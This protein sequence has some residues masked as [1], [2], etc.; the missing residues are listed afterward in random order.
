MGRRK[1][2]LTQILV[3]VA[4]AFSCFGLLLFIWNAFGGPVPFTPEGYR[5]KVPF[6]EGTQLAVESDV[7]I[8]NVSVGKVKAI[9]LDTT[10]QPE[11]TA[12]ATIQVDS[13][14]APIPADTRAMLRQKTL[15]G[16]TYVELTPGSRAAGGPMLAEGE[17]LPAAQVAESVQLDEIF[18]SLD[19]RTRAAFRVWM[20][21]AAAATKGRGSDI[22]YALGNLEPFTADATRLVGILDRQDQALGGLVRNAGEVFD[23]LSR[24]PGQLRGLIVNADTVFTTTA[25]R[26]RSLQELFVTLPTFQRE[27][28][29]TLRSAEAFSRTATPVL[30]GFQP[31]AKALGGTL[32]QVGRISPQLEGFSVGLQEVEAS[33]VQGF[34]ALGDLLVDPNLLPA[35]L[36]QSTPFTKEV[37]PLLTSFSQYRRELAGALGNL[38]AAT[39]NRISLGDQPA[40][41]VLRTGLNVNPNAAAAYPTGRLTYSRSNPYFEPGGGLKYFVPTGAF[42]GLNARAFQPCA[43]GITAQLTNGGPNPLPA[44]Y[45]DLTK[46]FYFA[47]KNN[48][49]QIAAPGCTLQAPF[50]SIGSPSENTQYQHVWP[51][52]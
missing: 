14:Y 8:S 10:D 42:K 36:S 2:K 44:R 35:L 23:A 15:L 7:R 38:A 52:P 34:P 3:S 19:A 48:T 28:R 12:V 13:Q 40:Y 45:F 32:K 26:N 51:L 22:S 20:Q 21:G 41:K 39:N 18:R 49:S 43:T 29:K 17:T 6:K 5:I 11:G 9:D 46:Q 16:E 30:R 24:R 4:F 47:N 37:T 31:S 50:A 25:R 1:P 27:S 33:S